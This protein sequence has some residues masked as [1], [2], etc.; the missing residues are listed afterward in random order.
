MNVMH[1]QH[2]NIGELSQASGVER[3]NIRYYIQEDLLDKPQGSKRGSYYTMDHLLRLR[4][5]RNFRD[6]G[7]PLEIIK[8][9]FIEESS[10]P[11][12]PSRKPGDVGV[13]AHY[14]LEEGVEL[15]ID[16][17]RTGLDSAKTRMLCKQVLQA[18]QEIHKAKE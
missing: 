4:R 10:P 18:L 6:Q 11:A 17:A 14:L 16:P 9:K 12:P 13:M 5:I 3:R 8:Q 7:W 15:V 2:F 1:D